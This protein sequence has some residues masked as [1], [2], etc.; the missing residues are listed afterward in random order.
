[1]LLGQKKSHSYQ[2]VGKVLAEMGDLTP[3]LG[4]VSGSLGNSGG[5]HEFLVFPFPHL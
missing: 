2:A 1:M 4:S 3:D 5:R